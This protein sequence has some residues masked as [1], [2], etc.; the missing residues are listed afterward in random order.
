MTKNKNMAFGMCVFLKECTCL[1]FR[2]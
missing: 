1:F 2:L